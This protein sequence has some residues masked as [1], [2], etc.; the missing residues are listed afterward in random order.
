M[1][2]VRGTYT[3]KLRHYHTATPPWGPKWQH[4]VAVWPEH[5]V[6]QACVIDAH[7]VIGDG[8]RKG[9]PYVLPNSHP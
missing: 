7:D 2:P 4:P 3:L 5:A 1:P 9:A 6:D 8:W